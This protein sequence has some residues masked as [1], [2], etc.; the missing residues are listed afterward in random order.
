M[1]T[2]LSGVD[3]RYTRTDLVSM[4]GIEGGNSAPGQVIESNISGADHPSSWWG[5][6]GYETD[7]WAI[8][9]SIQTDADSEDRWTI[10]DAGATPLAATFGGSDISVT[11]GTGDVI[12]LFELASF[13]DEPYL[14]PTIAQRFEVLRDS[15]TVD[16]IRCYLVGADGSEVELNE[17]DVQA[18]GGANWPASGLLSSEYVG[19]WG[20]L[21]Y[22]QGVVSDAPVDLLGSGESA[23]AMTDRTRCT[24]PGLLPGRTA[25]Y[26]KVVA[27]PKAATDPIKLKYPKFFAPTL[28]PEVRYLGRQM[29]AV[30]WPTGPGIVLGNWRFWDY[31]LDTFLSTPEIRG[32]GSKT[33]VMDAL[34]TRNLFEGK[35]ADDGLDAKIGTLYDED[36]EFAAGTERIQCAYNTI[37]WWVI[38]ESKVAACLQNCYIP[39]PLAWFP[40]RQRDSDHLLASD[41]ALEVVDWCQ[42][43]RR[44]ISPATDNVGLFQMPATEWTTTADTMPTGWLS[45]SHTHTLDNTEALDD[46][47]I[48]GRANSTNYAKVRPWHGWFAIFGIEDDVLTRRRPSRDANQSNRQIKAWPADDDTLMLAYKDG[49]TTTAWTDVSSAVACESVTVRI[50]RH[51]ALQRAFLAVCAAG[52]VSLYSSALNGTDI[53][54]VDATVGSGDFACLTI[55]PAGRKAVYWID[56]DGDVLGA[57][58]G[59]DGALLV[60]AFAVASGA[61]QCE[62]TAG[63]VR[64][65][66]G[67]LLV[68]V[69]FVKSGGAHHLVSPDG[70]AFTDTLTTNAGRYLESVEDEDG[71][72]WVYY[73]KA[74]ETVVRGI[75]VDPSG[76]VLLSEMTVATGLDADAGFGV[77]SLIRGDGARRFV[78][79]IVQS[80]DHLDIESPDGKTFL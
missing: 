16:R 41:R 45:R 19:T 28:A 61:D 36:I 72:R 48:R 73:Q 10:E 1:D 17:T 31:T 23:T 33:S 2:S 39:P 37:A 58:Y 79:T 40:P 4:Q 68:W 80:S 69:A 8:P 38:S 21:D 6:W 62:I 43:P 53:A 3:R 74:T 5:N 64:S 65:E 34:C 66:T 57:I 44:L 67:K 13:A 14:Y 59:G 49:A 77:R 76:T 27:T 56:A 54:T 71:R 12:A 75:L 26:L 63:T 52:A 20:R 46:F 42:E 11:I 51:S 32:I 9:A 55:L 22:G 29:V 35:V 7:Q 30:V 70:V 47:R 60:S 50:D 78:M 24:I 15:A 25:K 18:A